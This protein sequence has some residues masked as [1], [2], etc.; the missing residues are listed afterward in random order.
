[1]TR[2]DGLSKAVL[3]RTKLTMPRRQSCLIPRP[4]LT[5]QLD[6]AAAGS[7]TLISAPAGFGKTAL[8]VDWSSGSSG[9]LAWLS[10]DEYDNL[11]ARFWRYV[12]AALQMAGVNI[13][14]AM[15]SLLQTVPEPDWEALIALLINEISREEENV[16]LVL[17]DYH[18]M[19]TNDIHFSLGFL[20]QRQPQQ[21]RIIIVARADPPLALARLR[22]QG[23]L[24]ELRAA[25][26]R[27]TQDE[28]EAFIR[29]SL[30]Y[31]LPVA[32]VNILSDR[33]EGWAAGLQLAVLSMQGQP[34]A[35]AAAFVRSFS[36]VQRHVFNYLIEEVLQRQPPRMQ[37]FLLQTSVL[38]TLT[39]AL[40]TAVTGYQDARQI[41]LRLA[42]EHLFILPLDKSGEWYRY[43]RL[44]AG[45]M[46][47]RLEQMEPDLIPEL[48]RRATAW[49]A[50]QGFYE[51]V[52]GHLLPGTMPQLELVD[53]QL[54]QP[55]VDPLTGREKEIL[56]LIA[57]GYSN[58]QIADQLVI[59]IGTVKGHVN[60][61]L[62][63]LQAQSRTEAVVR[64]QRLGMLKSIPRHNL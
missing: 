48:R 29:C 15:E 19:Q 39:P 24:S 28:M 14:K 21:L 3:L 53:R 47:G 17:D 46:R 54:N 6:R 2:E 52:P 59:S 5:K 64:A 38:R 51:E 57:R 45:A 23:R 36:G 42:D 31:T 13:G 61:L 10:L 44:F 50:E 34:A 16:T 12:I 22:V 33:I 30:A 55:L 20:L 8:I 18:L 4:R 35:E 27:F 56:A 26:L 63:K 62:S 41:L 37:T 58:Q 40:C 7:V 49:Y 60:H 9:R 43:H 1:M 32:A 11:P 25:D